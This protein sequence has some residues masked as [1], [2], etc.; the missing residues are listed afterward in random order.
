M[1]PT[2]DLR[3]NNS[4][5]IE[6]SEQKNETLKNEDLQTAGDI[7]TLL[8]TCPDSWLISWS[9]FYNDLF[10]SHSPDQ[11]LLTLNRMIKT[12]TLQDKD[13]RVRA[14]KLLKKMT[15]LLSLKYKDIQGLL[16]VNGTFCS[17]AYRAT[18]FGLEWKNRLK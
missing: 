11:I 16:R 13:G 12:K 15:N 2:F 7:F 5:V 1:K 8:I 14:E 10:L 17:G 18:F 6:S 3:Q 9:S 4:I